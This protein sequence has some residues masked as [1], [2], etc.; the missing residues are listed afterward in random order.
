MATVAVVPHVLRRQ[1]TEL[2]VRAAGWLVA[3]GHE[4]RVPDEDAVVAELA[5]HAWPAEKLAVGLDL[6]VS[7][8]GDGTMLR[9]VDLVCPW[10]V[11]VLGV[12]AGRLGYLTEVEAAGL[13]VALERFFAGEHTIEERMT[14]QVDVK[15]AD[16]A[17]DGEGGGARSSWPALNEAVLGKTQSGHMLRLA[18]SVNDAEFTTYAADGVI[19]CTPTGSTAYN[20]SARGPIVSPRQRALV[21]TP[22]SPHML[23]DRSLVL[24]AEEHV[25]LRVLDGTAAELVVDGRSV[26]VLEPGASAACSAGPHDARLVKFDGRDFHRILKAKFGLSDR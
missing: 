8:G 19:V 5:E 17:G 12:N 22:V 24:G 9:T 14:L 4:I 26:G 7:A 25:H 21:V 23:F 15:G 16:V 11:P 10:G 2:A 20:L 13:E 6:A 18:V 1:A 3:H